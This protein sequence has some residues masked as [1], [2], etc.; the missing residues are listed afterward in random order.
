MN[1]Y[2]LLTQRLWEVHKSPSELNA[3]LEVLERQRDACDEVWFA[4]EYGFPPLADV[5]KFALQMGQAAAQIRQLRIVASLQISNSFGHGEYLRYLNFTGISWQGIVGPDGTTSPYCNC[6][7]DPDFL[8]YLTATTKAYCAWQPDSL[9]IDDDLRMQNHGRV[10]Y[11]CFCERCLATFNAQNQTTFSREELATAITTANDIKT[12]VAWIDF[13]RASMAQAARVMA[14][15]ALSV[16]PNC[17]L[18]LQ[19]C[20]PSWAGYQGPDLT[21][22]FD[23]LTAASGRPVGSRP[24]GGFYNDHSPRGMIDKG[25]FTSLQV[26][27]LPACVDDIRQEVENLPGSIGGKSI[28]G[29]M[30]EATTALAYGCTG[31]TFTPL[32]FLHEDLSWHEQLLEETA[33]W[34]HFWQ[35]YLQNT[36]T[37]AP[38][39]MA[40][41]LSRRFNERPLQEGETPFAWVNAQIGGVSQLLTSGIP[42]CWDLSTAPVA[43]LHPNAVNGLTD[44]EA[45]AI[46]S[47]NVI[48]DG[49]SLQ[50]LM[51]RG[52]GELFPLE[53]SP[54]S[55]KEAIERFTNDPINGRYGGH[56]IGLTSLSRH[57]PAVTMKLLGNGHTL[58][59]YERHGGASGPAATVAFTTATGGRWVVFGNGCWSSDITSAR[60]FQLNAAADW[61]SGQR[62]SL[63]LQTPAQVATMVRCNPDGTVVSVAV[64]N[65]SLDPSPD[66]TTL[67]RKPADKIGF[68][69]A[70]KE[71]GQGC[72]CLEPTNNQDEFIL[73]LPS[74]PPWGVGFLGFI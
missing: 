3:L 17:R 45:R 28:H 19:H 7:R 16:A 4:T 13:G 55:E 9:W 31:L 38:S 72:I 20:A 56:Y 10:A 33:R 53:V 1:N 41:V 67:I 36:G 51:Q 73:E 61:A 59:N 24:G 11:G 44:D 47:H 43:L 30:V 52:L 32:M 50:R 46:A 35:T 60:H 27:R 8:A 18:G 71:L 54:A 5:E 34:R 39:G 21:H 25:L 23:T 74:L 40:A 29:T 57:F 6:P 15:A 2:P 69:Y 49:E 58:T 64:V 63:V 37:A 62:L 70:P 12:R 42:L 22:V 48:T 66:L 14:D 26:E 65:C 68:W